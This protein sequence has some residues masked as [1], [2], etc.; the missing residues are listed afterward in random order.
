MKAADRVASLPATV[1]PTIDGAPGTVAGVTA[2]TADAAPVPTELMARILTAYA[3]PFVSPLM[4]TG[5]DEPGTAIQAPPAVV[6]YS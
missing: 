1:L 5:L 6:R 3:V 2:T 4:S